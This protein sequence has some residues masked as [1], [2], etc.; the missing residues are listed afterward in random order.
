MQK[1][2]AVCAGEKN[3]KGAELNNSWSNIGNRDAELFPEDIQTG[4]E[5][6]HDLAPL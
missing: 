5:C 6:T 4:V 1:L 3:Y 2:L